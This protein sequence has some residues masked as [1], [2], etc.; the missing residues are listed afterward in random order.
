[1]EFG[2]SRNWGA[3]VLR[4]VIA[5]IFGL[6]AIFWPG[7]AFLAL[8]II[9]GAYALVD[10][11]LAI[12]A[13]VSGHAQPGQWWALILEGIIGI[14][15]GLITFF[16]PPVTEI[17]LVYL[18]AIWAIATGIF[19]II[20]A[21]RLRR[22]VAGEWALVVA[23]ILSVLFGIILAASPGAG[24][25]VLMWI[26][27][28]YALVFGIAMIVLGFRLRRGLRRPQTWGEF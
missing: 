25:V 12:Y 1:M 27:G 6:I 21:F 5:I 28:A 18:I 19:E 20:A 4:G 26:I 10:G 14:G 23:G 9:Y 3:L 8:A 24:A 7:T 17:A 22:H 15:I 16:F 2:L 13:A 11:V